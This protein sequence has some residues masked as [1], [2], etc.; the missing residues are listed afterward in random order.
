MTFAVTILGCGFSGGVPR[1]G[2]GWGQCDPANP[3]NRRRRCSILVDRTA[4]DGGKTTVLVDTGPDL[5]EQLLSA[6]V[7][8]VDGVLYTHEH[9]DHIH[10][11]DD[12]RA[13][14]LANRKRVDIYADETTWQTLSLRFA[15]CFFTPPGSSYPPILKRHP[16]PDLVPVTIAGPGGAVTALPFM[17][18][19]GDIGAFGFRFG[20]MAYSPDVVDIPE[21]SVAALSG[22]ELWIV[23]A[24]WYR[25]HP[26]HF[27]LD[28]TL[29]W[30][31]RI[32]PK[33]AIIT[34]MHSDLDYDKLRAT[35]PP[36]VIPA[37]DGL[38]IEF[39]GTASTTRVRDLR[40]P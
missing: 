17:Q 22:V 11:I 15:Y 24:L 28:L 40:H 26:S 29:Q 39:D 8:R 36:N 30:I 2:S 32:K 12:L 21:A 1:P 25:P 18:N 6:E 20:G 14:F 38:R 4:P 3:K 37:Y 10:G 31:D 27:H 7:T 5:R 33:R 35:L 23:D 34:N 16:L 19:H 13:L 9:A